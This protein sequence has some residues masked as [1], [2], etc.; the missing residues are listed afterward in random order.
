MRVAIAYLGMKAVGVALLLPF[1][2]VFLQLVQAS[3]PADDAASANAVLPK[4]IANAHTLVNVFIAVVFMPFLDA[5]AALLMRATAA[6]LKER[7]E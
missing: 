7:T 3:A 4:R 1:F 2:P 5:T 6:P